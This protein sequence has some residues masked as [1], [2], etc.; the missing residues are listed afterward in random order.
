MDPLAV[1]LGIA[2]S[3]EQR[4][5]AILARMMLTE[6]LGHSRAQIKKII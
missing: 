3:H 6:E 2:L 1:A 5:I 4:Q